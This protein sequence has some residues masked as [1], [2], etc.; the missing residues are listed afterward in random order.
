MRTIAAVAFL[1]VAGGAWAQQFP[2]D[3]YPTKPVSAGALCGVNLSCT[4]PTSGQLLRYN[5]STRKWEPTT[6]AAASLAVPVPVNQGGTGSTTNF[7]KPG[8]VMQL[9]PPWS[10]TVVVP[11]CTPTRSASSPKR[12]VTYW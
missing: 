9:G 8:R 5:T 6:V 11:E 3:N 4:A 7:R 10:T 1:F 12:P 2:G